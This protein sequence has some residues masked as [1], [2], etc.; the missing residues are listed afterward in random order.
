MPHALY[1]ATIPASCYTDLQCNDQARARAPPRTV[2][3]AK[4]TS[5]RDTV[6]AHPETL[7]RPPVTAS[8][9]SPASPAP[10][11]STGHGNPST[12][13]PSTSTTMG[14]PTRNADGGATEPPHGS[15]VSL[16]GYSW[17]VPEVLQE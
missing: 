9:R 5:R 12:T 13:I 7:R 3:P 11:K 17:E 10:R 8:G 1:N 16:R 14:A 2:H 6:V 15:G 4:Q